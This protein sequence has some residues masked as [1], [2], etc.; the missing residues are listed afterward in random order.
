[1]AVRGSL[2]TLRLLDIYKSR[3][4]HHITHCT[5]ITWDSLS[6]GL[7]NDLGYGSQQGIN[8]K[9]PTWQRTGSHIEFRNLKFQLSSLFL[10]LYLGKIV[11]AKAVDE[12]RVPEKNNNA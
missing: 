2:P 3:E 12:T 8:L 11:T 4:E 7:P 9:I 5:I 1:M 10:V 6:A